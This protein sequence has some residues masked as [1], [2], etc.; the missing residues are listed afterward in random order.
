MKKTIPAILLLI[1]VMLTFSGCKTKSS[2]PEYQP[3]TA[4]VDVGLADGDAGARV[5]AE[6]D[7]RRSPTMRYPSPR[8]ARSRSRCLMRS[9]ASNM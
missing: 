6:T 1:A 7:I 9:T 2:Q 8:K 5:K 4:Y 3:Y